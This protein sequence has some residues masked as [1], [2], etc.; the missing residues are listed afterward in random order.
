MASLKSVLVAAFAL[1]STASAIPLAVDRRDAAPNVVTE[2]VWVTLDTTTTVWVPASQS[3][4]S[5]APPPPPAAATTTTTPPAPVVQPVLTSSSQPPPPAAPTDAPAAFA[6]QAQ[7]A[8]PSQSTTPVAPVAPVASTPQYTAPQAAPSPAPVSQSSGQVSGG[9][10]QGQGNACSGDV[11]HYDGGLGA[12]G[13]NVNTASDM[14]IALPYGLMGTLSNSNPYCGK[15][16]SIKATDGSI[17]QA[18]VGDKCMGCE[19][20]SIDLTDALFEAV[21]PNGDGRVHGVQWWFN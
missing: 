9:P 17:V 21:A 5:Q 11:T 14:Q 18:T 20:Q 7:P 2:T 15:S 3:T 13:W 8:Q 10:C 19:G 1:A 16:L 12:C 6:A 4:A